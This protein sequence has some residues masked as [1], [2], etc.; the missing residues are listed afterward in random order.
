MSKYDKLIA[1]ATTQDAQCWAAANEPTIW[2]LR[3]LQ[4]ERVDSAGFYQAQDRLEGRFEALLKWREVRDILTP[5]AN[6]LG[7]LN[8]ADEDG[9]NSVPSHWS[10]SNSVYGAVQNALHLA[11]LDHF[12]YSLTEGEGPNWGN[13]GEH[14]AIDLRD[15]ILALATAP[16]LPLRD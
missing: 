11:V 3:Y 2:C 6:L 7:Y 14:W 13:N 10:N 12:G 1:T 15:W 5:L 8:A 4:E 9:A 16:P